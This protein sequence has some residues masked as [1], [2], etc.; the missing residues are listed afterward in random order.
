MLIDIAND[1]LYYQY[2]FYVTKRENYTLPHW[3]IVIV[4]VGEWA[5]IHFAQY[6][7]IVDTLINV[8]DDVTPHEWWWV[9]LLFRLDGFKI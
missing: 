9:Y 3:R 1:I 5:G 6:I 8:R 7:L 4:R 2:L